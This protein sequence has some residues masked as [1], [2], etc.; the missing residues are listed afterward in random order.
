MAKSIKFKNDTYLDSTS[1]RHNKELLSD[2]LNKTN[3]II[4]VSLSS[5][6]NNLT[7]D[8]DIVFDKY[9]SIG[10]K[11]TLNNGKVKIGANVK[12]V[13]VSGACFIDTANSTGYLWLFINRNDS[14][15]ASNLT[16][17][18]TIYKSCSIAT[19]V[20]EVSEGDL[21]SLEIDNTGG[22][23]YSIRSG[24]NT[25]LTVEVVE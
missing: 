19:R 11:L 22:T 7:A 25:Y 15:V 1:I 5:Q 2:I 12:K 17:G 4:T 8:G 6:L 16:A 3:E 24:H 10:N 14:I 23:P 21:I 13:K 18:A 20:I 9:V